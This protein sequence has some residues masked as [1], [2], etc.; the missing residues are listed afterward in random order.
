MERSLSQ[1]T[2]SWNAWTVTYEQFDKSDGYPFNQIQMKS[3]N[4]GRVTEH[5][6]LDNYGQFSCNE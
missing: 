6:S 1:G 3:K 4:A 5:F 2:T